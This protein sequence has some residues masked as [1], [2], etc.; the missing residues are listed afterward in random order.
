M[1]A[2]T[3]SGQSGEEFVLVFLAFFS[4]YRYGRPFLTDPALLLGLF[5]P[6]F[7]LLYR[8]RVAFEAGLAMPL[9]L[10]IE[11]GIGFGTDLDYLWKAPE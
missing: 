11:L 8:K 7:T 2:P 10:G 6:L 5:L 4:T 3:S 1:R 9:L